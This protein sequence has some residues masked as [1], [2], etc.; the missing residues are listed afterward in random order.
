V[1]LNATLHSVQLE[2]RIR[3]ERPPLL[4]LLHG[5]GA[6]ELDLIGLGGGFDGRFHIASLRGPRPFGP[7]YTWFDLD[8]SGAGAAG[9]ISAGVSAILGTAGAISAAAGT[10]PARSY[11]MGFSMGAMMACAAVLADPERIAGVISH[12]GF[13]PRGPWLP[14]AP[15]GLAGKPILVAHGL[16]DDVVPIS[17]GRA[18]RDYF[19]KAGAAVEYREYP[20][21][22]GINEDGVAE[23]D[24]WLTDCLGG[25]EPGR[26]ESGGGAR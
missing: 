14:P 2:P 26:G 12:S 22:H 7:G 15:G 16:V 3:S 13:L 17:A 6:D 23:M 21:A 8:D 1:G 11:L 25:P 24:R 19:M 10:D 4:V 9:E 18:T 5:R 20:I